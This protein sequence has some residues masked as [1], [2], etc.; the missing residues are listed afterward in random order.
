MFI[1][2]IQNNPNNPIRENLERILE[3]INGNNIVNS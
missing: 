3:L 1:E 2:Y